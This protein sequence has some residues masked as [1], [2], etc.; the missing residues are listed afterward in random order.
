M[1]RR[2]VFAA[3]AALIAGCSPSGE[4]QA[5]N[6]AAAQP[7]PEKPPHCFFKDSETKGWAVRVEGDQA[8]VTGRAFRSD[9]RY[10]AILLDPKVGGAIAVVRPSITTNDTGFAAE[11]NWWDLNT[12]VPTAGI[13]SVE[14]RCGKALVASLPLAKPTG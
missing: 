9:A 5:A 13:E 2:V 1:Q 4:D 6:Q 12:T 7:T 3:F 11:G 8:V 10:K 14:I